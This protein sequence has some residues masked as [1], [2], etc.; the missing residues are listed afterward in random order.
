MTIAYDGTDYHCW[1]K[2]PGLR[3]I[4]Q[5]ISDAASALI[6]HKVHVHGASR[7]DAGV[8]A[9]GQLGLIETATNIPNQNIVRALNDRLPQDIAI[10]DATEAPWNFDLIGAVRRKLYRYTIYIA[11]IRPVLDIRFCW[12][13]PCLLDV[14]AMNEAAR[15]LI[16]RHDFKSFASAKDRRKDTVRTIFRLDLWRGAGP[17][18][19]Y[20]YIEVEGRSFLHN[21]VRNIVGTLVEVG[22][23]KKTPD[24]MAAIL[25]AKDRTAAGQLAPASGLCLMWIRYD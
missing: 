9:L 24:Q 7:T 22:Q 16:G 20:V 23:G 15:T 5:T 12:H 8:H 3:T 1:H 17:R 2:Q 25:A 10:L 4:Q 11:K 19:D 6:G 21:M 18:Q 13:L 14:E